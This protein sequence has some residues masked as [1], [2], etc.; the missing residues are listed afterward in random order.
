MKRFE[1]QVGGRYTARVS[2]K[3]VTVRVDRI[4]GYTDH[5]YRTTTAFDV[6]NLDTGRKLTFRSAAKFRGDRN[7][8]D[9]FGRII[10]I[11][12]RGRI[13]EEVLC[14]HEW[15]RFGTVNGHE[16]VGCQKCGATQ[17]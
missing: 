12:G 4:H 1:I 2:G 7:Q 16:D 6:T 5:K 10:A 9:R 13:T 17:S 8:V 15:H 11:S 3:L 14:E